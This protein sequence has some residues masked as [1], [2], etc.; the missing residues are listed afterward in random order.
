MFIYWIAWDH[1]DSGSATICLLAA[2]GVVGVIILYV[3]KHRHISNLCP[4][5]KIDRATSHV[6]IFAGYREFKRSEVVCLL[7]LIHWEG[8]M[9]TWAP[10]LRII[11]QRDGKRERYCLIHLPS[12]QWTKELK[13]L[14]EN[15]DIPILVDE[16]VGYP[17]GTEW[18]LKRL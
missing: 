15:C 8:Q 1:L 18:K 5:I 9:N 12:G 17:E 13:P 2:L 16:Q 3:L 10:E 4:I 7:A 6:S 14:S 11:T